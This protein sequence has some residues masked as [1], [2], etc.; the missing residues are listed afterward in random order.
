MFNKIIDKAGNIIDKAED[1]ISK[2]KDKALDYVPEINVDYIEERL[3]IVGYK[4]P[5]VEIS[6]T[7]PPRISFEIDLD[8]SVINEIEKQ[9]L[10][11]S[12]DIHEDQDNISNRVIVKIIEGL[13]S[14]IKLKEKLKFKNK[15]LSRISIEGSL[16]PTIKL[17]YLNEEELNFENRKDSI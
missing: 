6:I 5:R 15:Q 4:I 17:I 7:I 2:I 1:H 9:N 10:L 11:D 12:I 14:A 13:D 3:E 8:K 16:I